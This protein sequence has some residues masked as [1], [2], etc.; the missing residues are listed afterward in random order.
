MSEIPLTQGM[1]AIVDETD[2]GYLNQWKWHT[3]RVAKLCYAVRSTKYG[4][5]LMHRQILDASKGREVD[6]KDG[7]G[8]NNCRSNLRICN[9]QKNHFNLRNRINTSSI[10][11]GVHW[12]KERCKWRA[13]IKMGGKTKYL[14]R[15]KDENQAALA[16][17]RAAHIYFG[18]YARLNIINLLPEIHLNNQKI[19]PKLLDKV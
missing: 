13:T 14:G 9:H 2:Y 7:E 4:L 19:V 15:F 11:K 3:H 10:Y 5:I 1:V 18:E 6:H 16:Y 12:D 8:L 17:N